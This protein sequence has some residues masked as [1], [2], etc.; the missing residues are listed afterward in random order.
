MICPFLKFMIP[1]NK[2]NSC[3]CGGVGA[4]LLESEQGYLPRCLDKR[5]KIKRPG[6]KHNVNNIIL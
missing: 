4:V 2:V 1:T 3:C 6:E 5:S